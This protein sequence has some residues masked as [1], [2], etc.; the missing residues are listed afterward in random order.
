M[1]ID[2]SLVS[3]NLFL[4]I[5]LAASFILTPYQGANAASLST[6]TNTCANLLKSLFVAD[7]PRTEEEVPVEVDHRPLSIAER[8]LSD[9]VARSIPL[10]PEF[11]YIKDTA[12]KM[13]IRVWL[14]GG[15]ASSFLHY[16]KW[17]LARQKGVMDLQKDRFDYDF[18][19]IFRSTQDLDI[20]VDASPDVARNFQNSIAQ[21]YPH[22]LGSKAN[23]W[24]VRTLRSRMGVPGQPGFKE[25][26]LNES[27][28]NNQNTD[29]NSIGMVELTQSHDPIIRDL[30]HWNSLESVFLD[31]ALNNRISFFRSDRHFTTSRAKNGENP[32]ILSV[33]R[34]L[35]KAF[36]YELNFSGH[37]FEQMK[38]I[39]KEFDPRRTNNSTALRRIADTAKKLVIHAVNI[40]YAINKL[41]ELGLRQKLIALGNKTEQGSFAWWLNREPLRSKPVGQGRGRTAKELSIQVVAHETSSFL[42]YESITRSHSGEPNVL[43]SRQNAV[44]EAAAYGDGFY[45]RLG[46]VGARGTGLTIRFTV[47]PNAREG[48]DF[49]VN[50][51]FIVFKNKPALKVI[52]E[53]LNFGLDDL[54]KLAETNQEVQVDHSDLALLEK[55]KRRLN[56]TKITDELEKLLNSPQESDRDRLVQILSAF[57]NSAVSKL[58]SPEVLASVVK[59]IYGRVSPLAQSRNDADVLRY[60]RTVGPIIKTVD[61]VGLLKTSSFIDYLEGL[62]RSPT[63][64]FVLRKEAIF[65]I[66]LASQDTINF[67][68]YMNFKRNLSEEE[69][70]KVSDE[71]K[72][73]GDSQDSRKRKFAGELDNRWQKAIE[74]GDIKKIQ[75]L[76]DSRFFDVNYKNVSGYSLLLL[77]D[78]YKQKK[79]VEWLIKNPNYDFNKKNSLGF[80]EV[81][82]LGL[83]GETAW[84][85]MIQ[86]R[87]VEVRARRFQ[88]KERNDDGTPI[89]DFVR[90]DSTTFMMGD[91]DN[92]VLTTITKP[93]EIMSVPTTQKL[94]GGIVD[95]LIKYSVGPKALLNR[96]PSH[97]NQPS[98]FGSDVEM[99]PVEQVSHN[100]VMLW[101][102]GLNELSQLDDQNVQN[103]LKALLPN[104]VRGA[105]YDLPTD[106]QWELV[107]RNGGQAP[108][109]FSFGNSDT[110]LGVHAV[111]SDNSKSMTGNVGRMKPVF[112]N[113]KPIYDVHGL[114]WEWSSDWYGQNI[115]GGKDPAGPSSG[116]G[117]VV[118][119]GSW[120]ADAQSL[121]SGDRAHYSPEYRYAH[122]GFR[123]L[124]TIP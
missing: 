55:L 16:A 114:V 113:G 108:G 3:K 82:Q 118:R 23:K 50:G 71:I 17:D 106:A 13:G 120:Y 73:W 20:V 57:Q 111:Y 60:I 26:L 31:D 43:I 30:R 84:A 39:S 52:Q 90:F 45:T 19:N 124:R 92:K 15:T 36:Q 97:F 123:L 96:S 105:H 58:I 78:Y 94:W 28:F 101:I 86:A 41:D 107:A 70:Q 69:L 98:R 51:D 49:T 68:N 42:A 59:N 83:L 121:R 93:F 14:F 66:L 112:Y 11:Q 10:V 81:E 9:K 65:E 32:E 63:V 102:Q 25:A 37:D 103:A 6:S 40:E 56:A 89:V 62:S 122:V 12:S 117:R 79:I 100:D 76:I 110:S 2:G 115:S 53:S 46:K 4:K 35:V 99:N 67:E 24:E 61:S 85:D 109:E 27:D 21:R 7:L 33:L 88:V 77:A 38:E 95:I 48:T 74:N 119:G 116:S 29:S 80:T 104:H 18:T 8:E 34:L 22:F 75:A 44:G 54:L 1:K 5:I 91:G 64:S 87:R 47:D 72:K